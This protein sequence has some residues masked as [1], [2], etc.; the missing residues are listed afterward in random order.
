MLPSTNIAIGFAKTTKYWLGQNK[1]FLVPSHTI[2]YQQNTSF[3]NLI[4]ST[5]ICEKM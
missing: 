3:F 2:G 1:N 4:F 5:S